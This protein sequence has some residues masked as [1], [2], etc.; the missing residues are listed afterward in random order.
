MTGAPAIFRQLL[1]SAA[2][3]A[4]DEWQA[5]RPALRAHLKTLARL[6]AETAAG[7]AAGRLS[8]DDARFALEGQRLYLANVLRQARVRGP[9]VLGQL[10]DRLFGVLDQLVAEAARGKDRRDGA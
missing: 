9:D 6:G 1:L 3:V 2:A 10:P 5:L 4:R 7:L 8:T